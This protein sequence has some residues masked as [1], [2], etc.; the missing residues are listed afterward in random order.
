MERGPGEPSPRRVESLGSGFVISAD[1]YVVTNNHVI[2][3]ADEITVNFVDGSSLV[4]TLIGTDPKT[5]I[6]LLKVE[7]QE[8]LPFVPFGDSEKARVGDWVLAI[9]NPFGL[10]GSVSAGIISAFNRDINA[11]PYDDFIQTDAAINRGNSGGPL[12]NVE[13]EV[14]GVNTA[15]ISQTGLSIGIGFSVPSNLVEKVV[16]QL[17]EFGTTRRGWLGVKIQQI[18]DEMAEALGMDRAMGALVT[19]VVP[20][21]PAEDAGIE[22]GDVILTFDGREVPEMRDLPLMVA[23]TD[24]GAEVPVT[25]LRDGDE[26]GMM[27]AIGL[28]DEGNGQA[29]AGGAAAEPREIAALGLTVVALDERTREEF[30]VDE[31]IAGVA[32][33][34]VAEGSEAATRGISVGD[35]VVEVGQVQVAS[36]ED[37]AQ[38]VETALNS[39]RRTILLLVHS[40]RRTPLRA[41]ADRQLTGRHRR[42]HRGAPG[43]GS[44]APLPFHAARR[45]DAPQLT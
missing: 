13:G 12:F 14:I 6:A 20:G 28:L 23:D 24:V 42:S 11:G 30:Q 34:A 25:V 5:D 8:G 21:G 10:G 44:R 9:G 40:E 35:V 41:A 43:I 22:M 33:T 1:G 29:A 17:K 36:P 7:P 18:D 31:S 15:I 3:N 27:V 26:V 32:V 2:E 39:G 37:V 19:E 45:Q 16:A 4:A 38:Q